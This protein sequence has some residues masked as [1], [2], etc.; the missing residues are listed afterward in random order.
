MVYVILS[1]KIKA[2]LLS[3]MLVITADAV[4]GNCPG[5]KFEYHPCALSDTSDTLA[6]QGF[7]RPLHWL[8][9]DLMVGRQSLSEKWSPYPSAT[10]L[11][12][13]CLLRLGRSPLWLDA[14]FIVAWAGETDAEGNRAGPG[15]SL[16]QL[17]SGL[18]H[19]WYLEHLPVSFYA[20]GGLTYVWANLELPDKSKPPQIN[21]AFPNSPIYPDVSQDGHFWGG[22]GRCGI[23]LHTGED[24]YVGIGLLTKFT[25]H[26]NI[27]DRNLN[28]NST[29]LGIFVG[30]GD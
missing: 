23:V 10:F 3:T 7:S 24:W 19:W 22:Y 18:G 25:T 21:P 9:V 13:S 1:Q 11:A 5:L 2:V 16:V 12:T 26:R 6:S 14:S 28:I 30:A 20:A 4:F 29:A 15:T 27:L 8:N 17:Q